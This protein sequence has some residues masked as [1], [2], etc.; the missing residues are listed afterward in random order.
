MK[1]ISK[2]QISS[3]LEV[4]RQ[5]DQRVGRSDSHSVRGDGVHNT[6]RDQAVLVLTVTEASGQV[7]TTHA[8]IKPYLC[9]NSN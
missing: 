7:S 2:K 8:A 3:T 9:P 1:E 4:K 6:R 5:R